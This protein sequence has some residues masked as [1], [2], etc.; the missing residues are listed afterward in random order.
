MGEVLSE[1]VGV[2]LAPEAARGVNPA[3]NYIR[4]Q[5]NPGGIKG[6]TPKL[7]YVARDPLSVLATP[8]KGDVVGLDANPELTID[9]NKDHCD[10]IAAS[11]FRCVP[12]HIGGTDQSLFRPT[13]VVDGGVSDDSFTVAAD[14]DLAAGFLIKGNGFANAANNALH[15]T[16]TST[17]LAIK[18]ATGTLVAE[19]AAPANATL[20]VVGFVALA[21]TDYALD[22]SG[23]LTT[24][25]GNFT[26]KG[27][28]VGMEIVIGGTAANSF[29]TT[30]GS[31]GRATIQTIA[32]G[33]L[34][35]EQRSFAIGADLGTGKTIQVFASRFYRNYAINDATNYAK[36]TLHGEKEDPGAG[37]A[38]ASIY[39]EAEVLAVGMVVLTAP[40]E[41]KITAVVSFV[42]LDIL[43][44]VLAADR[45]AGPSTAYAPLCTALVDTAN[46]L[47]K[48][49]ITDSTGDLIAEV[50]SWTFTANNNVKAKKAQGEPGAG[51]AHLYGKFNYS[52][53][54]E[55]YFSSWEQIK[56]MRDNRALHWKAFVAN[57]QFGF[58]LHLPNVGLL[59]GD[60]T[61]AANEPVMISFDVPAFREDATGSTNIAG[62]MTVFGHIP[63]DV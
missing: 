37:T 33:K 48:V 59:G 32:S 46:D 50:T 47:D 5:P 1:A 2:L 60:Q 49:Q 29:F 58:A 22:A 11:M 21:A 25:A 56:A 7:K 34:T 45:V 12:K 17:A 52:V 41:D 51:V 54:V 42:G 39:T 20:D 61:Y 57:H 28:V 26:T 16:V 53:T 8:E 9:W 18:V 23:D 31:K 24:A 40:L 35:L 62:C 55:A 3:A 14:G 36:P 43:D 4:V 30:I 13:V 38:D 63:E 6:W 44:P 10:T 27:L 15:T 19:A